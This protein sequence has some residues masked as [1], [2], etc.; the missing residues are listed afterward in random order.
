M[1]LKLILVSFIVVILIVLIKTLVFKDTDGFDN[2]IEEI[3][4][5]DKKAI[6]SL[7]EL[8]KCKT[9]SYDNPKLENNKEF[10]KLINLLPKLYPYVYK[11][12]KI[13]TFDGRG[14]LFC[15]KGKTSNN[16]A[17]FMA[18]YDVVPVEEELWSKP[19]FKGI[20]EN[21]ILWGRGTLD[22]KNTFNGVLFAAN[23]LLEKGFKPKHDIYLAFSGSEEI[24]GNG[25]PEIVKYLKKNKVEP[26]FVIDEGGAVVENIFPGVNIPCG[27]VGVAEKGCM[28]LKLRIKSSGGHA[29]APSPNGPLSQLSKACLDIE[30][31]PF[32]AHF[33]GPTGQMFS[34]LGK[35]ST[36][37][38][39]MIFAN[40]WLFAPILDLICK[41]K[42]GQLNALVRT[43][44]AFTQAKGSEATNVIPP[45]AELVLNIRISPNDSVASVVSYI[46]KIIKNDNIEVIPF[47]ESEPSRVSITDCK[48][49]ILIK[50]AIENTWNG[51]VV[52][53]YLMVQAS[54]SRH[55]GQISDKVYRFSAADMSD[56]EIDS[57]HGVDEHIRL[58][59]IRRAVAFFIRVMKEC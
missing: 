54:D 31:H 22:T 32:K 48:G 51:C 15:I 6:K 38:Y 24:S 56:E 10:E 28:D 21:N 35:K 33:N 11:F 20:I 58:D 27:L 19:A 47:N 53:P 1:F 16:P 36:F 42:G 5:D 8:I 2:D 55:Y 39:R 12:A 59:T 4:F 41:K 26:S 49:Y 17:V 50:K 34:D 52:A 57:I 9:V 18:H 29:S 7:Q 14:I 13:K 37:L 30:A 25:A 45:S 40:L 43:T 3:E 23:T 46:K 44:T